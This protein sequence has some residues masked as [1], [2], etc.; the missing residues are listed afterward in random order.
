MRQPSP[1]IQVAVKNMQGVI[2]GG[3]DLVTGHADAPASADVAACIGVV[4]QSRVAW[5]DGDLTD[6][7][8][9]FPVQAEKA[10]AIGNLRP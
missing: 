7:R 4:V 5:H 8:L 10:A 3:D 2:I 1:R 6:D 9:A